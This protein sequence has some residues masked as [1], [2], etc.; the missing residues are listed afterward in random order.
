MRSAGLGRGLVERALAHAADIELSRVVLATL[1][2]MMAAIGLYR[3][4]GFAE[5]EPHVV[6]PTEG[7]IYLALGLA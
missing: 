4:M 5:A 2:G 3:S 1:P 6:D 7:V